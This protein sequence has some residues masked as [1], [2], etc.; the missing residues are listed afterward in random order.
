[1]HGHYSPFIRYENCDTLHNNEIM[2]MSE[3]ELKEIPL[4]KQI[5]LLKAQV[6]SLGIALDRCINILNKFQNTSAEYMNF[7]DSKTEQA[8][9]DIQKHSG[10]FHAMLIIGN[11]KEKKDDNVS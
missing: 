10:N 4:E 1:M 7:I 8:M 6:E 2:T 5:V 9:R 3:E 11:E